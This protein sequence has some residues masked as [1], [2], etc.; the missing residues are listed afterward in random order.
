MSGNDQTSVQR[1]S[2]KR[3]I[4]AFA[5]GIATVTAGMQG[6]ASAMASTPDGPKR[7][8]VEQQVVEKVREQVELGN[9]AAFSLQGIERPA[10]KGRPRTFVPMKAMH[11]EYA[12]TQEIARAMALTPH[13][14]LTVNEVAVTVAETRSLGEG[15]IVAELEITRHLAGED[16]EWVDLIPHEITYDRDGEVIAVIAQDEE[17]YGNAAN[18][19]ELSGLTS[20]DDSEPTENQSNVS[21]S[22]DEEASTESLSRSKLAKLP[23]S[24]PMAGLARTQKKR[25]SAYAKKYALKSNRSYHEYDQD[26]TNFVS[27]AMLAGG[28]KEKSHFYPDYRNDNAWWYGGI[29]RNSWTWSGAENF[30]RMARGSS[31]GLKRTKRLPN[32]YQLVEGDILQY[33][34]RGARNMRHTMLVTGKTKSGVPRLSYH[35]PK[36]K[37]VPFT[38][39]KAKVK[40]VLWFTHRT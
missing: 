23:E 25:A 6:A 20:P 22:S 16:D 30:Y 4:L 13:R 40:N 38:A 33:K 31:G 2:L 24:A 17:F 35:S 32:V 12:K 14:R 27:Q 26:C 3:K 10:S 5:V 28:W 15:K 1:N 37:N 36:R 18:N 19:D 29:P 34:P 7:E 11:G 8:K 9:E 39:V 21:S